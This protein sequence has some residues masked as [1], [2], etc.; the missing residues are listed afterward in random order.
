[1]ISMIEEKLGR[2]MTYGPAYASGFRDYRFTNRESL[3][4]RFQKTGLSSHEWIDFCEAEFERH[5]LQLNPFL[6][7]EKR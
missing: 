2:G 6:T 4:K 3:I 5:L 7:T 1:M